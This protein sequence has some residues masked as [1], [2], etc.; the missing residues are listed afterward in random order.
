MKSDVEMPRP[1]PGPKWEESLMVLEELTK[2]IQHKKVYKEVRGAKY[3]LVGRTPSGKEIASSLRSTA[4]SHG[5]NV[6]SVLGVEVWCGCVLLLVKNC[7]HELISPA[8]MQPSRD[9]EEKAAVEAALS[10][11]QGPGTPKE[12]FWIALTKH[13]KWIVREKIMTLDE[14]I[15]MFAAPMLPQGSAVIGEEA[16]SIK[17]ILRCLLGE[18]LTSKSKKK[19][20]KFFSRKGAS[21]K[22]KG[23]GKTSSIMKKMSA[24]NFDDDD[25]ILDIS[26]AVE[27]PEKSSRKAKGA[28]DEDSDDEFDF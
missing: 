19:G 18:E 22:G 28:E 15:G 25:D 11:F 6:S 23:K 21:S 1:I 14:V 13:M 10:Q 26:S 16:K 20:I 3:G 24:R 27:T 2:H 12:V 7:S 4:S 17:A 8:L 9:V 5:R